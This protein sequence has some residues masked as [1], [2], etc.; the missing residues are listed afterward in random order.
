MKLH[1]NG[2]LLFNQVDAV[3]FDKDGTLIDIHHYW[4]SMISLR[5]DK[6]IDVWFSGH[7]NKNKIKT[8]LISLLGVDLSTGKMKPEGPV[9]IK[10][11]PE[12]VSIVS[13]FINEMGQPDII[14]IQVEEL[15]QHVDKET[16]ID[17]SHLLRLLPGVLKLLKALKSS[18]VPMFIVTTDLTD[19]AKEAVKVL[20]LNFYFDE[21]VGGDAVQNP[22]PSPD[23]V[24]LIVNKY[25]L[26][27]RNIVVVGDHVVDIQMGLNAGVPN[28]IGEGTGLMSCTD[29][30]KIPCSTVETLEQLEVL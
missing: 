21:I 7:E 22:K 8:N 2:K 1:A 3:L 16:S 19:R 4:T 12:I 27:R 25:K 10:S 28:N 11:R 9:G 14:D 30:K 24:D 20:N 17:M 26:D 6:V 18:N 5:A 15:F 29:L 13:N 23:L